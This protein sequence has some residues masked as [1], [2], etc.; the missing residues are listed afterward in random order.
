M[1]DSMTLENVRAERC[2][3]QTVLRLRSP[4][5][6]VKNLCPH[7][8]LTKSASSLKTMAV[9]I[10]AATCSVDRRLHNETRVVSG[11]GGGETPNG[12]IGAITSWKDKFMRR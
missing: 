3:R 12:E 9:W 5:C 10:P 6:L 7:D 2:H 8:Q 11:G 1:S 4:Q